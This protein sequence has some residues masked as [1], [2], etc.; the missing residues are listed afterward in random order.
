MDMDLATKTEVLSRSAW[1]RMREEHRDTVWPWVQPRLERRSQAAKHPI[2]DFLFE[3]YPISANKLLTWHPGFKFTCESEE[4]DFDYF[5]QHMYSRTNELIHISSKWSLDQIPVAR[6]ILH[7]LRQT[8]SRTMRTGCF[9][10]HEW[11]MVLGQD[12]I[13][14]NEWALRLSQTEIQ[15]TIDDV[16]LRCT[17]FDAF[18]FFTPEARPLN[19]V[20][21]TRADQI[22][23]DQPGCLHANMDLYKHAMRFA[24]IIG[25]SLIRSCF[26]LARDIR[27]VDMQVAPYDFSA[28]GVLPIKVETAEGRSTF[29]MHQRHFAERAN[30][31]RI[32]MITCLHDFLEAIN[33]SDAP[34]SQMINR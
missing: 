34:S 28:L 3:Y 18:R 14:H 27:T 19:P 1:Q 26:A 32:Q 4:P 21:L 31:L 12:T 9:G 7:F 25:S 30:E 8:S 29:A 2:D 11:A 23:Y 6:E 16:G 20:Q 22:N 33:S 24:P 13:R 5:P 10:L 15:K 17:H